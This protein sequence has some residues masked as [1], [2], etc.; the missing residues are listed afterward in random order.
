M[1]LYVSL[2]S[3]CSLCCRL[4][5]KNLAFGFEFA[6]DLRKVVIMVQFMLSRG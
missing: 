3:H 2:L 6:C 1:V 4:I 5:E